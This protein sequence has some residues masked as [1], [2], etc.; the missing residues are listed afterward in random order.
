MCDLEEGKHDR[1]TS[2]SGIRRG[3]VHVGRACREGD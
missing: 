2:S 1:D 3:I